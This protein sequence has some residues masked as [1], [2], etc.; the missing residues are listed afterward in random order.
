MGRAG[1]TV[2]PVLLFHNYSSFVCLHFLSSC[3]TPMD[4]PKVA[5]KAVKL[6]RLIKKLSEQFASLKV[7]LVK[8]MISENVTEIVI[9]GKKVLLCRRKN[10]KYSNLRIAELELEI[11]E[12]KAIADIRGD[13]EIESV[14]R[15]IQVR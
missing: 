8:D 10:K 3:F 9:S 1:S 13:F 12:L 7:D 5:S 4:L 15:F 11:K 6:D 14:T 2:A